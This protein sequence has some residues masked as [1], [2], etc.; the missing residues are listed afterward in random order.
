MFHSPGE[1]KTDPNQLLATEGSAS[2]QASSNTTPTPSTGCSKASPSAGD[3]TTSTP[4]RPTASRRRNAA[5]TPPYSGLSFKDRRPI[6]AEDREWVT[7]AIDWTYADL[8]KRTGLCLDCNSDSR[9][10]EIYDT[11]NESFSCQYGFVQHRYKAYMGMCISSKSFVPALYSSVVV[12]ID[13]DHHEFHLLHF[14]WSM[15]TWRSPQR[16]KIRSEAL[17]PEPRRIRRRLGGSTRK[18]IS[19]MRSKGSG[20]ALMTGDLLNQSRR[21][22][23]SS[24]RR[25][26]WEQS[27]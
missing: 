15:L 3:S 22:R 5:V 6:T 20:R 9:S 7:K 25:S 4:A 21:W 8:H 24:H 11:R 10:G 1:Q 14:A 2:P 19:W 23:R 12:V 13:E 16:F 27:T 26:R 17:I 18:R